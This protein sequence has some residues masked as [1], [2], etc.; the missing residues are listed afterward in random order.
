MIF[1]KL[2]L[3]HSYY[4][5]ASL[6]KSANPLQT[7]S[8]FTLFTEVSTAVVEFAKATPVPEKTCKVDKWTVCFKPL[9]VLN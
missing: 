5:P 1:Q 2:M 9:P 7:F 8:L 6:M 4:S 3:S